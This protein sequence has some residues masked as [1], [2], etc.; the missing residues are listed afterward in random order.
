MKLTSLDLHPRSFSAG[1]VTSSVFGRVN[2]MIWQMA[3]EGEGGPDFRL[4]IRWSMADYLWCL[5]ANAGREWGV[6]EQVP[7][8]G[9]RL[10]IGA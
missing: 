8:K 10:T 4:F 1:M 5:I 2:A 7:V 6:P 9:E 3:E